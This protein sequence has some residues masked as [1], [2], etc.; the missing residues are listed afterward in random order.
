MGMNIFLKD[1]SIHPHT[2]QRVVPASILEKDTRLKSSDDRNSSDSSV[3]SEFWS[4]ENSPERNQ[5]VI[6]QEQLSL[7]GRL[8]PKEGMVQRHFK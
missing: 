7:Q 2:S 4:H 1:E 3:F 5:K 8:P 6:L